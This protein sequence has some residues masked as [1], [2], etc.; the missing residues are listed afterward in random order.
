ME[1]KQREKAVW[2]FQCIVLY[3][4]AVLKKKK[5]LVQDVICTKEISWL[6]IFFIYK[7]NLCRAG[8]RRENTCLIWP[9]SLFVYLPGCWLERKPR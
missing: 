8:T 2:F 6:F 3:V 1:K 9:E 5:I 4:I 7:L